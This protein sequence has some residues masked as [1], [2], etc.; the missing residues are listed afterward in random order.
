[1]I[2]SKMYMI[3]HGMTSYNVFKIF[4]DQKFKVTTTAGQ[5]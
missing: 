3:N 5:I 2:E 1:L 4:V